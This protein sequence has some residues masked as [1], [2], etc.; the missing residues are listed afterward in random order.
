[1]EKLGLEETVKD[2]KSKIDD[3]QSKNRTLNTENTELHN[4]NLSYEKKF[5]FNDS[6]IRWNNVNQ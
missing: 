3:F 4:K 1:M 5:N 6:I 2:Q